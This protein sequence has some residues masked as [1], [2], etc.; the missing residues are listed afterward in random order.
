MPAPNAMRPLTV[1]QVRMLQVDNVVSAKARDDT[2]TL[3]GLGVTDLHTIGSI[4]PG[5]LERFQPKGQF[6]HYRG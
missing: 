4:V 2:R 5:Y 3:A 6:T 1:D